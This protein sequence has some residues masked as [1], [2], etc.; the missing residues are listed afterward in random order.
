MAETQ[1]D[2]LAV[3]VH[4]PF[5]LSKCPY[6]DFNSHV[7]DSI[8]DARWRRALCLEIDY[9]AEQTPGR[10]VGSIFFGGGTPS[11][12]A[13]ETVAAVIERIGMKWSLDA[14]AEITLEANPTSAEAA[15]FAAFREAGVNRLSLGVQALDDTALKFLG[16]QHDANEARA[17]L[18]LARRIFPRFSFDLIYARPE[19]SAAAWRQELSTALDMAAGHVSLYQLT[20]EKGT[21]FYTRQRDGEINPP[22]EAHAADLFDITNALAATAGYSAYEISNYAK[23]AHASRHNLAYWRYQDYA[24]IGPGAHGRLRTAENGARALRQH[25]KPETWLE[26]VERVGHGSAEARPLE[27]TEQ[28]EEMLMMGLRLHEGINLAFFTE[29]TGLTLEQAIRPGALTRLGDGG[30]LSHDGQNLRA[31]DKGRNVLNSLL[32]ELFA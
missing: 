13:P 5:C 26:A 16:R 1:K 12:M 6:C 8:D 30:L 23:P 21:P 2:S 32:S 25:A 28:A 14:A 20:I 4:W 9:W 27:P 15:R 10:H 11:L 18:D 7:R 31:T 22:G 17:A 29:R 24:G 3:Y 19:Q